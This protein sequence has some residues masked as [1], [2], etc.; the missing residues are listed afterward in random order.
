M[1]TMIVLLASLVWLTGCHTMRGMGADARQ[2]GQAVEHGLQKA[3]QAIGNAV[4]KSGQAI[5]RA[6]E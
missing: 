2:G 5:Q 1:K 4:E 3:G 6:A